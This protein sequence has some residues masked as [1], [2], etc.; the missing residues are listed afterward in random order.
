M[1]I[2]TASWSFFLPLL[3]VLPM[4]FFWKGQDMALVLS[5]PVFFWALLFLFLLEKDRLYYGS[6]ASHYELISRAYPRF[7]AQGIMLIMVLAYLF[8]LLSF[9]EIFLQFFHSLFDLKQDLASDAIILAVFFFSLF[10][11][12]QVQGSFRSWFLAFQFFV[13]LAV[14]WWLYLSISSSFSQPMPV[15]ENRWNV[16]QIPT[17][18]ALTLAFFGPLA[19]DFRQIRTA[20]DG[21]ESF[22]DHYSP[23]FW[24]LLFLIF[25][26]A[27]LLL[28][29]F[30]LPFSFDALDIF[31]KVSFLPDLYVPKVGFLYVKGVIV[32]FLAL[33]WL[34]SFAL[35]RLA[36]GDFRAIMA[37]DFD[38]V[39]D[40]RHFHL[41]HFSSYSFSIL[42]SL[43]FVG[44][45]GV[46]TRLWDVEILLKIGGQFLFL[47]ALLFALPT[48]SRKQMNYPTSN[49]SWIFVIFSLVGAFFL[50][51]GV[52]FPLVFFCL[53]C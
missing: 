36:L 2:F 45:L 25:G 14:C 37:I 5:V 29:S 10:L 1:R 35:W 28:I 23:V 4:L 27:L 52:L 53:G 17:F 33:V 38:L 30:F 18:F 24:K 6:Y 13:L 51:W 11:P 7:T 43:L 34:F 32:L 42:F 9:G 40:R 44:A 47:F 20:E 46:I 49:L 16:D 48:L 12:I 22:H 8:F 26:Y 41:Y 15:F 21:F 19:F 3:W 39:N 50:G 31:F